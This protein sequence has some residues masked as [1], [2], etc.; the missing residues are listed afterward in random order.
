MDRTARTTGL[1]K[2]A[3]EVPSYLEGIVE[4]V[5]YTSV[6]IGNAVTEIRERLDS[7]AMPMKGENGASLKAVQTGSFPRLAASLEQLLETEAQLYALRK[8]LFGE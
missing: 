8:K 5:E 4:Q 2:K 1:E 6:R 3:V 7:G